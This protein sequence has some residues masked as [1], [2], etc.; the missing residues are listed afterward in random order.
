MMM[1]ACSI[2]AL[3]ASV[4][5]PKVAA[6]RTARVASINLTSTSAIRFVG[7]QSLTSPRQARVRRGYRHHRGCEP[8][9]NPDWSS[10]RALMPR[11]TAR[12][13]CSP[14]P[15]GQPVPS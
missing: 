2:A 9:R 8:M 15:S 4:A 11:S 10:R 14:W 3:L 5:F 1:K 6:S 13:W 7:L 12:A